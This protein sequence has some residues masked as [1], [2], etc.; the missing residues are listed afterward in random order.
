M[1]SAHKLFIQYI[2]NCH[3]NAQHSSNN[4]S[5]YF[6]FRFPC[7]QTWRMNN[8]SVKK[9]ICSQSTTMFRF[10]SKQQVLLVLVKASVN[11]H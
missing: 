9:M 3:A 8:L 11:R 4:L 10:F 7:I 6:S 2:G 5:P 1:N